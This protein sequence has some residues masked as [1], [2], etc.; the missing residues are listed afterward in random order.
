MKKRIISGLLIGL[1]GL[2]V[3]AA[4]V[5]AAY[6][7]NFTVGTDGTISGMT[8]VF[9][10]TDTSQLVT[11]GLLQADGRDSK[12]LQ[13]TTSVSRLIT[14]AGIWAA[15][16]LNPSTNQQFTLQ[17]GQTPSDMA[18]ITGTGGYVTIPYNANLEPGGDDFLIEFSGYIN[19]DSGIDKYILNQVGGITIQV[20]TDEEI[21]ATITTTGGDIVLVV[22]GIISGYH[23]LILSLS[24]GVY[25]LDVNGT[26]DTFTNNSTVVLSPA[27]VGQLVCSTG[28][29]YAIVHNAANGTIYA[30]P[31]VGQNVTWMIHRAYGIYDA[32]TLAGQTIFSASLKVNYTSNYTTPIPFYV[33]RVDGSSMVYPIVTGDYGTLLSETTPLD[34]FSGDGPA[35]ATLTIPVSEIT[36]A[37]EI[38]FAFRE[39]YD[40]LA[41]DLTACGVAQCGDLTIDYGTAIDPVVDPTNDWTIGQND[42][43]PYISSFTMHVTTGDLYYKP[44]NIINGT[45]LP[46]RDGLQA[47]TITWGTGVSN[48]AAAIP[49]SF[50]GEITGGTLIFN[51]PSF[52]PGS[53]GNS[54]YTPAPLIT[55]APSEPANMYADMD[56]SH[57][58]GANIINSV[59]TA[60]TVPVSLFWIPFAL[61]TICIAGW[62]TYAGTKRIDRSN[63]GN[64]TRSLLFMSIACDVVTAIWWQNGVLPGWLLIPI[65]LMAVVFLVSSKVFSY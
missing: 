49:G 17:T 45:Y 5:L 1:I 3:I 4:P 36:T 58:P 56:T 22:N 63:T 40:V 6:S 32:T 57:I 7:L 31:A 52:K 34:I 25:T 65:T 33:Y 13:G 18:I 48:H 55:G 9:L 42:V 14:D 11:N 62:I 23:T 60:G 38:K 15:A 16:N 51:P 41:Q 64:G 26:A 44:N 47:G 37:S 61:A 12:V 35:T 28:G 53:I 50:G 54:V 59:F 21:T 30:T 10:A 2:L 29:T 24:G 8:P 19:T 39:R 20:T 43:T 27:E 46:D